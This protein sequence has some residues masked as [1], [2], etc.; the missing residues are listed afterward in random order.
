MWNVLQHFSP[1]VYPSAFYRLKSKPR[2]SPIHVIFNLMHGSL[3]DVSSSIVKKV[4]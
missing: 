1:S 4:S 2:G 3:R